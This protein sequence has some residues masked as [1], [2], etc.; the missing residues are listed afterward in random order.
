MHSVLHSSAMDALRQRHSV[1]E[2]LQL[3]VS[4][5]LSAALSPAALSL[6][7]RLTEL[8]GRAVPAIGFYQRR[9]LLEELFGMR[10]RVVLPVRIHLDL[11]EDAEDALPV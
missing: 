9:H 3:A 4:A 11:N 10:A 1:R 5:L 7:Q 8:G 2:L 6:P